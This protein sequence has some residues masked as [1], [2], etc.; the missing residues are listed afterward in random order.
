MHSPPMRIGKLCHSSLRVDFLHIQNS[1]SQGSSLS[2]PTCL[3]TNSFISVQ[4]VGFYFI[5]WVATQQCFNFFVLLRLVQ[6]WPL[7]TLSVGSCLLLIYC[8]QYGYF[9][10]I[11]FTFLYC[12]TIQFSDL[13]LCISSSSLKISHFSM[14]FW[15]FL[16]EKWPQKSRT[17]YYCVHCHWSI[18]ISNPSQLSNPGTICVCNNPCVYTY[19]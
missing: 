17:R 11:L 5:L 1:S 14:E 19:L 4:I 15:F 7:S 10:N 16:L 18:L 2:F 3:F 13:I 6:H 8:N 9:K 12:S